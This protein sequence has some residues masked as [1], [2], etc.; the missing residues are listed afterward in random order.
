MVFNSIYSEKEEEE[1]GGEKISAH[2]DK[3]EDQ[4]LLER[5]KSHV[6]S[7]SLDG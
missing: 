2:G 7:S 5:T 6:V 4:I 3:V 1:E